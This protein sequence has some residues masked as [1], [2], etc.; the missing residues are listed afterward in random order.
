MA[1]SAEA[2]EGKERANRLDRRLHTFCRCNDMLLQVGSEQEALQAICKILTEDGEF[3]FAWIGY[4]EDDLGKTIR[5]VATAGK[6]DDLERLRSLW[7]KTETGQE[8]PG[9]A[10]R[11]GKPHWINDISAN[12]GASGWGAA[13]VDAGC[14]SSIALPLIARNRHRGLIDLRG[15]L[16]LYSAERGVFDSATVEHYAELASCVT[17]AVA[18]LRKDLANDLTSG[19]K[20]LRASEERK[21]AEEALQTARAELA[22]ASR[23][24]LMG[25]L[26]AS[27][28]H[29]IKQPL[30]AIVTNG[31]AALR[32][33]AKKPPDLEEARRALNN[34]V[35][36]GHRASEV[37]ESVRTMFKQ[38]PQ[39][40]TPLDINDLVQEVLAL[41]RSEIQRHNAAV[42]T[43]LMDGI[44]KTLADRTQLQQVMLNLIVNALEAM[45]A[46]TDRRRVLNITSAIDDSKG[47][48]IMVGDNGTGIEAK[49]MQRIF[50]SFFTTKVH[51]MGMGLS[52]CRSIIETHDGSL[53]V[54]S[55]DPHGTIFQVILP[56]N[57]D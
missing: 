21:R 23:L 49:N 48:V 9:L 34:A 54:S 11:T 38:A 27:I 37:V 56:T 5:P 3:R 19:V 26:A 29:E 8:P 51:G 46:V 40:K 10:V 53:L 43:K 31:N 13:V 55:G 47:V 2:E 14:A 18:A 36:G 45:D 16:N 30:A 1:P 15:A 57:V 28:A 41:T 24:T 22:R 12:C 7:G 39:T 25:Q 4:C 32:W 52:I 17:Q 44:P 33:L 42:Q 6:S 20:S 50:D 35:L